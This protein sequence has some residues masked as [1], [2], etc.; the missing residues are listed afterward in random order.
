MEAQAA[1]T[2]QTTLLLGSTMILMLVF[3]IVSFIYLFQRKL[4]KR[5]IAY[6]EIE[7]LLKKQELRSAYASMEGQE[8]E[9]KR[10]AEELHDNMGSLLASLRIYTDLLRE[11]SLDPETQRLATK[12]AELSELTAV[13]TRRI[14]HELSTQSLKYLGLK[15][16]IEELCRSIS[17]TQKIEVSASVMVQVELSSE[18]TLNIYRIV[19]ELI[20]NTLKHAKATHVRLE[21]TQ[22]SNNYLS[23]IYEDNGHG[24]DLTII[25][26]GM[27]LHNLKARVERFEG[28]VS[29]ESSIN[30]GT[31]VIIEFPL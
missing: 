4:I 16:P 25:K 7:S 18:L 23:L 10:I 2:A 27:G 9:R 14:S 28:S 11:K 24:F 29:I 12:V 13:E 30:K 26:A 22:V 5:K 6:N 3:A 15:V 17:E 31:T 19:Q 20:T 8:N 1:L 21:L